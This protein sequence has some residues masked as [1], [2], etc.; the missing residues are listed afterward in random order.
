MP[1]CQVMP[2]R[3]FAAVCTV[4]LVA[5]LTLAT[6]CAPIDDPE[7]GADPIAPSTT[8]AG[9]DSGGIENGDG[10]IPETLANRDFAPPRPE[11]YVPSLV[12][13]TS[14]GLYVRDEGALV[15]PLVEPI[16]ERVATKIVD[17]FFGGLVLQ[18]GQEPIE[19]HSG[20]GDPVVLDDS[21]ARL[22]DVGFLDATGAVHAL[23]GV[24]AL[25][26]VDGGRIETV[27][28]GATLA[29]TP[30]RVAFYTFDEG[31]RLLDLSAS[32]GL[33]AVVL[34]DENCGDL[35]FLNSAGKRVDLG[36][37]GQPACVVARRPAYGAVALSPDRSSVVYTELAYRSDG[38]VAVTRVI[39]RSLGSEAELF[40]LQIGAAGEVIRN[41][42]FD[43]QRL[44]FLKTG[45]ESATIEVLSP[46]S[47]EPAIVVEVEEPLS[48]T[49]S[50]QLLLV[51]RAS[52]QE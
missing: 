38:L 13:G 15:A 44:T 27:D 21:G 40:D 14:S 34:S 4:A 41:L 1:P 37:P 33:H 36:G 35:I 23:L 22:L 29:G 8:L 26:G 25:T 50:R 6:A 19:W 9:V 42:S 43:G 24:D 20:Q 46:F 7:L 30:E 31:Q 52:V 32:S 48:V 49:F 45:L 10:T 12:I 11:G 39:G 28:L 2:S 17:D 3:Q 16:E 47:D 18:R 51:G 5:A